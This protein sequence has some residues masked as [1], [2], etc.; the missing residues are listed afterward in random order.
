MQSPQANRFIDSEFFQQ[1]SA[2]RSTLP[3]YRYSMQG[4]QRGRNPS[5][6]YAS[7]SERIAKIWVLGCECW[8]FKS[9]GWL[10]IILRE[11]R[12]N[13]KGWSAHFCKIFN[14][15]N[16]FIYLYSKCCPIFWFPL[17]KFFTPST[18]P[19]CFWEGVPF[20]THSFPP[21]LDSIPFSLGHQVSTGL[22]WSFPTV[23]RQGS[24]LLHM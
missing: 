23:T 4:S 1:M 10:S 19:H 17:H 22:S 8:G 14:F 15:I 11:G 20:L 16:Y 9:T 7:V 18:P 21:H 12:R 2:L 13:T 3:V 24:P 5:S 6:A